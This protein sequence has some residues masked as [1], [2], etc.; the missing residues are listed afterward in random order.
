MD[1]WW[2]LRLGMCFY[3]LSLYKEAIAQHEKS[4][5][6]CSMDETALHLNKCYLRLDQPL[7]AAQ[8]FKQMST[9]SPGTS[10]QIPCATSPPAVT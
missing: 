5:A 10:A 3:Q 1:W 6:L 4:L 8:M 2:H 7:V 9:L